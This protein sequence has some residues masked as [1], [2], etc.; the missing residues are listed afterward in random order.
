MVPAIY[1]L[2]SLKRF[3]LSH[4]KNLVV[5]FGPDL[6]PPGEKKSYLDS[7]YCKLLPCS[8]HLIWIQK[9]LHCR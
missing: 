9:G 2:S 3:S 7:A 6:S 1:V 8:A 4:N 5:T